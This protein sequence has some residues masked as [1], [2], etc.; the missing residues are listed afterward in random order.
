M[1]TH[2]S[3]APN[4]GISTQQRRG[5]HAVMQVHE[6]HSMKRAGVAGVRARAAR[7]D[8]ELFTN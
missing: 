8:H 2:E 5:I 7:L 6:N 4:N 1:K 3:Q